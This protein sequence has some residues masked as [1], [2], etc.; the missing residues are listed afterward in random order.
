[1]AWTHDTGYRPA[2]E[3]TGYPVAVQDD[4]TEVPS[5][6]APTRLEIIGWRS[7]CDCGWRGMDFYPRSQHP[8]PTALAPDSVDGWETGTAAYAEWDRHLHRVLP[9]L[10][11]HDRAQQ[12]RV[13][14]RRLDHAIHAARFAGVTWPRIADAAGRLGAAKAR[15]QE[16]DDHFGTASATVGCQRAVNCQPGSPAVEPSHTTRRGAT[17]RWGSADHAPKVVGERA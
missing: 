11:V 4:G 9:E 2:Y 5:S 1:M 6:S 13:A 16:I 14:E 7:A 17:R 15:R 3:H 8:S 10:D 12:L